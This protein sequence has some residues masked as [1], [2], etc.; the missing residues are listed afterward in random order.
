MFIYV[1]QT[2]WI[3]WRLPV[4]FVH[5]MEQAENGRVWL[6]REWVISNQQ[7]AWL[8]AVVKDRTN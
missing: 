6:T 1:M 2:H 3:R 7:E 8:D 4:K 5:Y